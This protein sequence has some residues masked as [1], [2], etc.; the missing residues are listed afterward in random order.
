M[1]KTLIALGVTLGLALT[2]AFADDAKKEV[3]KKPEVKL[4]CIDKVVNGKPVLDKEGKPVQVCKKMKKHKKLEGT[5]V[6][7]KK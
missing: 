1:K 6:P 2:P 7:D 4:V 5:K 3:E